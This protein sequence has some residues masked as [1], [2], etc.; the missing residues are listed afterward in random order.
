MSDYFNEIQAWHHSLP[1]ETQTGIR[2]GGILFLAFVAGVFLGKM[3]ARILGARNFDAALR[4]PGSTAPTPETPPGITPTFLAGLLVCLTVWAAAA[5][6]LAGQLGRFDLADRIG[7]VISR[8]WAVAGI[9]IVTLALAGVLAQRLVDGLREWRPAPDHG[10]PRN[11]LTPPKSGAA[12]AVAAGVYVLVALLVLLIAADM[13]DWPLTRSSAEALW[14]LAQKLLTVAATLFIG[15][16]GARWAR[17]LV[18]EP[19]A[20]AEKRAGQYTGLGI[21]CIAL[22][23]S[24]G[25]LLSNANLLLGVLV[26]AVLA[27][28]LWLCRGYLPDIVAGLQLR[29]QKIREVWFDGVAWQVAEVGFLTT[30]V[31]REG[32]VHSVQNRLVL[33]ARLHGAPAELTAR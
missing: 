21:L 32:A 14:Q 10:T 29:A 22:V 4:L 9:L 33:D 1:M 5:W 2:A 25:V 19:A 13:F 3:A 11:G 23:L 12:D 18:A 24:L 7:L 30:Q 15:L 31:C 17:D 26:L 16:L 28:A 20:T 8:A 27:L 6:W